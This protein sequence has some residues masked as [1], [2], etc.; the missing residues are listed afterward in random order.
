M[1]TCSYAVAG[2]FLILSLCLILGLAFVYGNKRKRKKAHPRFED[3]SYK[4][5]KITTLNMD[6]APN[7]RCVR[8]A[9]KKP[10][11]GIDHCMLKVKLKKI[12]DW[13]YFL[14]ELLGVESGTVLICCASLP[15][16]MTEVCEADF[17]L[18][19]AKKLASCGYGVF[20][21]DYPG[22]GLSE[23]LNNYIPNFDMLV[24]DV[25]EHFS[26]VKGILLPPSHWE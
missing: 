25:I 14:M 4:L 8:E 5:Q 3:L 11:L 21:L 24:E 23:G 6:E 9:F 12:V 17:E 2:Q 19:T 13:F 22:F 16:K 10:I 26:K 15:Y 1:L 18:G 7:R 20:A